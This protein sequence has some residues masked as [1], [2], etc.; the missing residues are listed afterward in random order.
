VAQPSQPRHQQRC[1]EV[2]CTCFTGTKVQILTLVAHDSALEDAMLIEAHSRY[3]N[4]WYRVYLLYWYKSTNP[5]AA[6]RTTGRR[7][8][9]RCQD[10]LTTPS[11]IGL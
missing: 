2:Q 4:R 6:R 11:R 8:Q 7:S 9:R 3:G 5:D 10:V 1:V